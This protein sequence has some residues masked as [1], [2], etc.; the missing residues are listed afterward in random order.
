MPKNR[1][2]SPAARIPAP[3]TGISWLHGW[4]HAAQTLST[5]GLP[6]RSARSTEAPGPRHGSVRGGGS[7]G[8][9]RGSDGQGGIGYAAPFTFAVVA[10]GSLLA[11]APSPPPLLPVH[12]ARTSEEAAATSTSASRR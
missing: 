2:R 4:H 9:A 11:G 12:P 6:R 5:V 8:T 3:S 1:T 10:P 7:L